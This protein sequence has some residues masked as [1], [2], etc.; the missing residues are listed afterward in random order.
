MVAFTLVDK[1]WLAHQ[2]NLVIGAFQQ[3]Q[4]GEYVFSLTVGNLWH[5]RAVDIQSIC[6]KM[7]ELNQA[8]DNPDDS[9]RDDRST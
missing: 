2:D 1:L 6:A 9:Q 3:D 7:L 8:K 4:N 5:F